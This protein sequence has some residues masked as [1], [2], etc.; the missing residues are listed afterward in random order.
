MAR[1]DLE[2]RSRLGPSG[3]GPRARPVVPARE[4]AVVFA[5]D[6]RELAAVEL[7]V[8]FGLLAG[9]EVS[10]AEVEQ[11]AVQLLTRVARVSIVSERRFE[12]GEGGGGAVHQLRIQVTPGAVGFEHDDLAE[13][14]GRLMEITERW[15]A[16]CLAAHTREPNAA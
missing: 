5:P 11:L 3:G 2:R 1:S 15:L 8:N 9:R 10:A 7:C 4:P 13:L 16:A 6:L 14:R 12:L